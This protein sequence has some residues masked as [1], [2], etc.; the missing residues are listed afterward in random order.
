MP[1]TALYITV[2]F[3]W[4]IYFWTTY[5]TYD[6]DR[7]V[8]EEM[9]GARVPAGVRGTILEA[10][11][12]LAWG[13]PFLGFGSIE[14]HIWNCRNCIDWPGMCLIAVLID[15]RSPQAHRQYSI[16]I[17]TGAN[18]LQKSRGMSDE[19]SHCVIFLPE[20]TTEQAP[21][22]LQP[23]FRQKYYWHFLT[24][25]SSILVCSNHFASIMNQWFYNYFDW[26]YVQGYAVLVALLSVAPS[27]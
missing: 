10:L 15:V 8:T 3:T 18:F 16:W 14:T 23:H 5:Q 24:N 27:L 4:Y 26:S 21:C 20:Y 12:L 25:G 2:I 17:L 1:L 11:T 7:N 19:H 9:V 13:L 22:Y 6:L